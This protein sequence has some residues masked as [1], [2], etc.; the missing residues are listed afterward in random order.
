MPPTTDDNKPSNPN[1][2]EIEIVRDPDG[3]IAVITERKKDGAISFGIYREFER[4]GETA[5][6]SFLARRHLQA[7]RRVLEDL[8]ERLEAAEDRSRAK[9]RS[10]E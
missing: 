9:R 4:S 10:R 3:V 1:Y 5:R 2:E 6:G 8:E 7:A